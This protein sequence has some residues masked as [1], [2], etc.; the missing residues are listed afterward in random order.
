MGFIQLNFLV[1]PVFI[2]FPLQFL[3]LTLKPNF[4]CRLILELSIFPGD[5]LD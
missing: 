3:N 5:Q 4:I 2:D 1:M